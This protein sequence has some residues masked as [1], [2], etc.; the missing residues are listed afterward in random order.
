MSLYLYYVKGFSPE[1]VGIIL[2]SQPVMMAG[3]SPLAGK[4]SDI[5]EPQLIASAGMAI[6]AIGLLLLSLMDGSTELW[7]VV[8]TLAFLGFGFALFSSP[9]TNAIMS[10]V[11]KRH[12]GI[13]SSTMGTM[14]LVG[15]VLSLG[16]ATLFI[17]LYLGEQDLSEELA[18]E[19]LKSF[20][21]A[22]EV[23]AVLCL[24]GIGPSLARGKVRPNGEPA[25]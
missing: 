15:Q 12:Y 17:S 21:L 8:G 10:S 18:P 20:R 16:F 2:V 6:S 19:F 25:R 13:A 14:R 11:E 1:F 3:F 7:A 22:F 23:F 4:L 9:N 5:V 24:L